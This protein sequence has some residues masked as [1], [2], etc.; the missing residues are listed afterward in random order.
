[1]DSHSPIS[2]DRTARFVGLSRGS[3]DYKFDMKNL[4][5]RRER[6]QEITES[7]HNIDRIWG[8]E[9]KVFSLLIDKMYLIEQYSWWM[10]NTFFTSFCFIVGNE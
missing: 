6:S 5:L 2:M 10:I 3:E 1:M 7:A 4:F 9:G 8:A